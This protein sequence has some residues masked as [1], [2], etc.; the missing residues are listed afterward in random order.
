MSRTVVPNEPPRHR[1]ALKV[2]AVVFGV[3]GYEGIVHWLL[4]SG[5]A[6]SLGP[7]FAFAPLLLIGAWLL[8]RYSRAGG[9]ALIVG[10]IV[11]VA[12]MRA[13]HGLPDFR[14]LYPV[15]HI[16]AHMLLLWMFGRSLRAGREP[17]VTFMARRVHGGYLPPDIEL[18]T[19]RVTLAWCIYFAVNA[20]IS[21]VLF[22]FAP[23]GVWSWFAN[24]L[25][26]PLILLMFVAEY[27]YRVWR[28]P[29]FSHAS[30]FTAIRA[31]RDLG[32]AA[33]MQ[34]R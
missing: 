17:L 3:L 23:L 11:A 9:V 19:R 31:A 25:N 33:V 8:L 7:I 15:P 14:L 22:A 12:I 34:G 30:F 13:R 5:R 27:A 16:G 21:I 20:A 2:L 28:Y 18:Y 4:V 29:N 6:E 24:V 32:R 10:A 26:V 1:R